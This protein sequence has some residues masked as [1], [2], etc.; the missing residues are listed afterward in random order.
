MIR[1]IF[2]YGFV[3]VSKCDVHRVACYSLFLVVGLFLCHS[4][5]IAAQ[6]SGGDEQSRQSK[7][8]EEEAEA[9][10]SNAES[11]YMVRDLD[12]ARQYYNELRQDFP[13]TVYGIKA[14]MRIGDVYREQSSYSQALEFYRR[15]TNRYKD[16]EEDDRKEELEEDY[17]RTRYQIGATYY[18]QEKYRNVFSELRSFVR[19]FPESEY[20]NP[21]YFL[22]G[23][24]HL[25]NDNY[26]AAIEA[27]DLVGTARG[28]RHADKLAAVS[29]GDMFY[30]QVEDADLRANVGNRI[31]TARVTTE[32][33]DTESVF[34]EQRGV[35]SGLFVG[36]I[37]TKLGPPIRTAKLEDE[38]W[39]P[40]IDQ[41]VDR[42][43][44]GA[45][46]HQERIVVL[47]DRIE[48]LEA[49]KKEV[50][51]DDS[52]GGQEQVDRTEEID[53]RIAET[54]ENI[55]S[56]QRQA[57]EKREK[58]YK[59]IDEAYRGIEGFL[60][61]KLPKFALEKF[62]ERVEEEQEEQEEEEKE[63]NEEEQSEDLDGMPATEE[64]EEE[65]EEEDS[66]DAYTKEEIAEVRKKALSTDT[67][68]DNFEER[69]SK[70]NYWYDQLMEETK[71]ID[72]KGDDIINVI[73]EDN[74]VSSGGDPAV[75]KQ[76]VEVA[77]DA[78][79]AFTD[80]DLENEVRQGIYGA[81]IHLKIDDPDRSET[82]ERDVVEVVLCVVDTIENQ[83]DE[84]DDEEGEEEK[85]EKQENENQRDG[86][87]DGQDTGQARGGHREYRD[88]YA[89]DEQYEVKEE[90]TEDGE[91]EKKVEESE[92]EDKPDLIPDD[93]SHVKVELTE[94]EP[95]SGVFTKTLTG[96]PRGIEVDGETLN[97]PP[98]HYLRASY[99]D[100][101]NIAYREPWVVYS[102][103]TFVPG[104]EGQVEAPRTEDSSMSRQ[105]QLDKGISYG[106]LAKIYEELG[107]DDMADE[108]YDRALQICAGVARK[109]GLTTLG[110][111]ATH[112]IWELYFES[113]EPEKAI[114]A[115]EQLIDE[116]PES[117]L[118]DD[119]YLTMAKALITKA[120]EDDSEKDGEESLGRA[121]S[122]LKELIDKC[123]DSEH[124]PE[125]L[126]RLG[127]AMYKSGQNGTEYMERVI[128]EYPDSGY[129]SKAL[130]KS[131]EHAYENEDYTTA[132]EYFQR[133]I[134]MYPDADNI[135]RVRFLSGHCQVRQRNFS[136]ALDAYRD[137][138]ENHPGSKYAEQAEDIMDHIRKQMN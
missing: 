95:H 108:Y 121:I 70:L 130:Q 124:V 74:Q 19:E 77:S 13:N 34:L 42:L 43:I 101:K 72:V 60:E 94:T 109:E 49:E 138:I 54:D 67:D 87:G 32:S 65:E 38:Y 132:Y 58:A 7:R 123:P 127:E 51:A 10:W 134:R 81:D 26:R 105:A 118:V 82:D 9:K 86:N 125:A 78:Y 111:E 131:G 47:R 18:E 133:I 1:Q 99:E 66:R 33:G 44:R 48:E 85:Q 104:A 92:G 62:E 30:V 22:I 63:Q 76:Q 126:F 100:E 16:L 114:R 75:R 137:L 12:L 31:I 106:E 103:I 122:A 46:E 40:V 15:M 6:D 90:E 88:S 89:P 20:A 35:E 128:S 55:I 59:T 73:Y 79:I 37:Q 5:P 117:D 110:Q 56:N 129:A 14:L 84:E 135:A 52:L 29:P 116:F 68:E 102:A 113:G 107:L 83:E 97:I 24:A 71:R 61:D 112:A 27:F 50:A 53:D 23:E 119:A 64:E 17:I 3:S 98:D 120:D 39:S 41:Q 2:S 45:E 80:E 28:A 69:R 21:A 96:T 93:V 11:A 25:N 4:A 115:C 36:Q 8:Q 57:K 136:Q 91:V